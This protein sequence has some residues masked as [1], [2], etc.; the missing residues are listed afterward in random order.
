MPAEP[1]TAMDDDRPIVAWTAVAESHAFAPSGYLRILTRSYQLPDGRTSEWDLVDTGP[2]VAVLALTPE[3]DVVLARQYR[4]GPNAIL[5]EMPGGAIDPGEE[6][7]KA[8]ERELREETGYAGEIKIVA[9]TWLSS[10][11]TTQR[12]V[13]L[14]QNCHRVADPRPTGDEFCEPVLVSLKDF[15]RQL[16]CGDL[17]DTDLGYLALDHAGLL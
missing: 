13:A 16:R 15:R 12:F 6:P 10:T 2:T 4:P 5:N 7:A 11:A 17:T 1:M 9:S 8:A 14:A 3:R